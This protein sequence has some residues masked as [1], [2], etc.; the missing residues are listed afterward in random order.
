MFRY[1]LCTIYSRAEFTLEPV[2]ISWAFSVKLA[3][4]F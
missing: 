1:A 4:E 3:P 2:D